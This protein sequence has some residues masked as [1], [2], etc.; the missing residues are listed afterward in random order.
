MMSSTSKQVLAL[1][2]VF[3]L[4]VSP[5]RGQQSDQQPSSQTDDVIRINTELVQTDVMV[6]DRRGRFVDGLQPEEF[7][8]SLDGKAQEVSFFERVTAGSSREAAQLA[9]ARGTTGKKDVENKTATAS[10]QEDRGRLIFFFLDDLHLSGASLIRARKALVNYVDH[11]MGQN[12]QVAIVSTSG[13]IG[14]LQ[15]LTDNRT[16]LHTAIN[17]LNYKMNPEAYTGKTRISEYMASQ[18]L[19]NGNRELYAYLLESIKVEQQ[20]GPGI[21]HGDHRL[22]SSYS[23]APLLR[24]RLRQVNTQGRMTTADTLE[25]LE[26]LIFSSA[27]LPGRKVVF[28]LSDGFIINERKAG[29]MEPLRR[30]TQAAARSGAV[31]YTMDLRGAFFNLGSSVDASTNEYIDPSARR[32]GVAMGEISATQEPLRIIADETGGRAILNANAI[33]DGIREAIAETSDYYLLA[34]RPDSENVRSEKSR[35]KVSVKNRPDLRVRL[36][37]SFYEPPRLTAGKAT[38]KD[39]G[40]VDA[41]KTAS[42]SKTAS[43][44]SSRGAEVDLLSALGSLYPRKQLPVSVSTGY[45]NAPATGMTLKVSMQIERD[46]FRFDPDETGQKAEVDVIGTAIDDRGIIKTF[47]QLVTVTPDLLAQRQ[48]IPVIWNQQLPVP[49]GLYQVR[50]AV[51][52]RAT[53]RTGSALQWIE[54]PDLARGRFDLSSIFLGE[55]KREEIVAVSGTNAPQA[56]TV[57]VDHH[58]PRT[59]VLRFQTYVYNAARGASAPDVWIQAQ[60]LRDDRQVVALPASKVPTDSSPD[61]T[62]LPYWAEIGLEQLPAGRYVLQVTATDRTA[63]TSVSQRSKFMVE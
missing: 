4:L 35:L 12:D 53:G 29:A 44:S 49:P 24:N 42:S 28:F 16:V 1:A 30:I 10:M 63:G 32:V 54:I 50:V 36:R 47:K 60:V 48:N 9:A 51:R 7:E 56:I 31:V 23:A 59:S 58:F 52:E 37:N 62:R 17:R 43:A 8:L 33:D 27:G 38:N 14:F 3:C 18:V 46:A 13:Q 57:D 25:S 22:A 41:A 6:F 11:H 19:D 40:K 45:V 61:A 2:A 55:R 15:Q 34:W 20:S 5:L 39:E 26:G 21:R